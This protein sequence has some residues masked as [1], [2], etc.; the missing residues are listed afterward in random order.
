[1][2]SKA[3]LAQ[4]GM[5]KEASVVQSPRARLVGSIPN[6]VIGI[7][8]YT[9]LALASF[10]FRYP[11]VHACAFGAACAAALV[12]AYLAYSLLFVTRMPCLYC[13]IAHLTNWALLIIVALP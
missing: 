13:W 1:M 9:L 7:A 8:Y 4:R 12:S 5:L 6:S 10:F 3:W 2:Q 11:I